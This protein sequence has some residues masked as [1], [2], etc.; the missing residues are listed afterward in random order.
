MI[1]PVERQQGGPPVDD[2]LDVHR[3]GPEAV[4]VTQRVLGVVELQVDAEVLV[5][6]VQLAAVAV[7]AVLDPDDRLAEVGQVEQQPLLDLLELA[8]LDLVRVVLVVVL[9]AE[10]LVPAAEVRRQERVDERQVVV[11]PADL[12]DLLPAQAE[13][14]VPLPPRLVVVAFVVFLAELPLVPALLDVAEQL[15]AELVRVE[16]A[17]LGGH[18]A[19]V[20][21]GVVDELRGLRASCW[22]MIVECQ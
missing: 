19:G 13:L 16:P 7:V 17:G 15:D 5:L 21:V 1:G 22:V 18:R 2:R 9:E 11:D 3:T 4:E 20:V 6:Q 8:A 14:L 10:E 12:E